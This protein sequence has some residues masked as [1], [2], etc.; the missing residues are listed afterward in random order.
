MI[1]GTG[2][3]IQGQTI[4]ATGGGAP[5]EGASVSI[6]QLANYE[7]YAEKYVVTSG[8]KTL[9]TFS[10]LCFSTTAE[11]VLTGTLK[12]ELKKYVYSGITISNGALTITNDGTNMKLINSAPSET[13]IQ[14][15]SF[16]F[17]EET[18]PGGGG[19]GSAV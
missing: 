7:F 11:Y 3:T 5:V 10:F 2:I 14:H 4:S 6:Q 12:E 15:A 16:T 8:Q 19:G 13:V 18:V 17:Y 9:T 1:A